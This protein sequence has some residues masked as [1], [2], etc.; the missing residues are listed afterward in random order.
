MP[1]MKAFQPLFIAAI[2]IF[3]GSVMDALVKSASAG[4]AI[5]AIAAWRYVFGSLYTGAAFVALKAQMPDRRG[6]AIHTLRGLCQVGVSLTF[7][8]A[9]SQLALAE[10]TALG[11]VAT[12]MVA[13][14]AQWTIGEKAGRWALPAALIGFVGVLIAIS[15]DTDGAPMDGARLLGAG[16]ALLSALFFAASLILLR[17]RAG[18]DDKAAVALFSNVVPALALLPLLPFAGPLPA[19]PELPFYAL[20]GAL[21]VGLWVFLT[22]AYANAPAGR[23]APLQYTGLIWS[24]VVGC[25]YF[26]ELPGLRFFA[27]GAIIIGACLMAGWRDEAE[28]RN[29]D[30]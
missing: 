9:L 20:I 1:C 23:L 25:L 29:A 27:G 3:L 11:F 22:F 28:R 16:A 19:L 21:G 10:A 30:A 26:E 2:G 14:L 5:I 13:P 18:C 17:L 7:F 12:I 4:T 24:A 8:W 6:V 15:A